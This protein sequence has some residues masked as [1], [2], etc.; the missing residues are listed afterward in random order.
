MNTSRRILTSLVLIILGLVLGL[1][2]PRWLPMLGISDL[3]SMTPTAT[4]SSAAPKTTPTKAAPPVPVQAAIVEEVSFPRGLSAVGSL[5]AEE[6]VVVSAEVGGRITQV[7]FSE[8]EPVSKGDVLVQLDDAVAQAE[9]A[10]AQANLALAQSKFDRSQRLQSAGFVS[11]EAR[12]DAAIALQL[13]EAAIK[14]AQARL[15]KMRIVA[16]FDGTIGLRSV[17]VGEYVVPGQDIAPLEAVEILKADFRLPERHINRIAPGQILTINVDALPNDTFDG[18]VYAVSPVV[19]AGGRSVLV[20]ATVQNKDGK[21]YPGMFTRIQL[22]TNEDQAIVIPETALSP[23]GQKQYVYKIENNQ[24]QQIP[25]IL[26]ERRGPMVEIVDGLSVN[27]VIV[28][29]GLQRMRDGATVKLQSDPRPAVELIERAA[30]RA[31]ALTG[32]PS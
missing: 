22:Q 9:L 7:N 18:Q 6:S 12:E 3:P 31:R 27:D 24:A 5:R 32:N 20:R 23:S 14:L 10:Q 26:G 8:G 13:Q 25:V 11:K 15:D 1:F 17:S 2:A 30:Q 19:D 29:S 16:P 28:V 21:L 4:S